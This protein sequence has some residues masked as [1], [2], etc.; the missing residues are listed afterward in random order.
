MDWYSYKKKIIQFISILLKF[1]CV[2]G[3]C[4]E[5][6]GQTQALYY[7]ENFEVIL[8]SNITKHYECLVL[9][10]WS[11]LSTPDY[12]NIALESLKQEEKR[13]NEILNFNNL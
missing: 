5:K 9:G 12:V 1:Y 8:I 7:R 10:D 11:K 6:N 3:K 13:Y 4:S 2:L